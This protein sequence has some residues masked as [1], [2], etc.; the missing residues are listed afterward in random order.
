MSARGDDL[1]DGSLEHPFRTLPRAVEAVRAL[2]RAGNNRP[3]V[4]YLREGRHQLTETLVLGLADGAPGP[5][6]NRAYEG[7]GAGPEQGEAYLTFAAYRGERAVIS[8]GVP[9]T[10]WK[11]LEPAPPELPAA[12]AGKVWVASIPE[13]LERFSTL[14]DAQ[15]RLPRARS[16]GFV[17][18]RRGDRR[19]LYFPPGQLRNWENLEDVEIHVRPFR[20]WVTNMLPLAS[21]DEAAGIA[22]TAVSATYEI[23][24]LPAWV[25]NP[26]GASVWVENVLEALD[27]PGEWVVNTRKRKVYLWP[28]DPAADGSPRNILAPAVVE[29]IRIE[30]KIDYDGPADTPVRGIAFSGLT[31]THADRRAWRSEEDRLGWGLQHDWEMFDRPTAMVRLRGAEDC[32]ITDCRFVHSGGTGIRLDL[33]AQ[34]TRIEHCEFAHLGEAGI[35]LAGYGPGTKDVNHHNTVINN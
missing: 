14:F 6:S 12:A 8:G 33:H 11:K 7:P 19:T 2:R 22:K 3:A 27:E 4:I 13:G 28:R 31:F 9:V 26:S 34:R 35:L 15:G 10:G 23:G 30:G 21:V 5:G 24:P 32:R 16:Q 1:S 29:L 20:P 17:P 25:H 18:T